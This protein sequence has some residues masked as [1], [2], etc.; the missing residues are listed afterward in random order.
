M[1]SDE[2]VSAVDL[3][4]DIKDMKV[5]P[6]EVIEETIKAIDERNPSINA[7]VYTNYDEARAKAREEDEKLTRGEA[8]RRLLRLPT[9]A[10]DFIP[11]LPGWPGNDRRC[12]GTFPYDR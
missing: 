4:A 9:A 11:G 2:Y 7:F 5:S 3:A 6:S 10:K 8:E 1:I 12:Q